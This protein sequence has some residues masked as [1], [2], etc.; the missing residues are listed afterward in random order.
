L[1]GTVGASCAI[2]S[3]TALGVGTNWHVLAP[4]ILLTNQ[5]QV[6]SFSTGAAPATFYRARAK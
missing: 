6:L 5:S 3:A 4:N 1:Y 2:E